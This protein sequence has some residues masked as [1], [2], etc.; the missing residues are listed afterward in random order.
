[1]REQMKALLVDDERYA[2]QEL[3]FLLRSYDFIKIAGEARN[4][5]EAVIKA[6][7]LQ[8]DV[9]FLDMEMPKIGGLEV[10]RSLQ[11]L[12]KKPL[13]VFAT[14]YPQFAAKAFRLEAID[15]LL[16][17]YDAAEL[18][19]TV[20]RLHRHLLTPLQS[21]GGPVEAPAKK[22]A[23]EMDGE[24]NYV[25]IQHI[26]YMF[27]EDKMTK[28][29]AKTG[30]FEIKASLRE[31]EEKLVQYGFFRIHKSYLINL[32]YVKKLSPWFNG[33]YLLELHHVKDQLPV[34]RNYVKTL[35]KRLVW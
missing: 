15:Y 16:K 11:E 27:R 25:L 5:E 17:P 9:V 1:M 23:V 34:S 28:I 10:A 35:K 21:I 13:I 14:A 32:E 29:I 8:P 33:A 30:E 3:A 6:V 2:R 22:L 20:Q 18:A 7:Q 12:K 26:Y 4:G 19:E 24:I 31:M